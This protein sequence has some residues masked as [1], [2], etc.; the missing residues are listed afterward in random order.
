MTT[1]VGYV[2]PADLDLVEP[3]AHDVVVVGAG[4]T[5]LALALDLSLRGLRPVVLEQNP[6]IHVHGI[7]SRGIA[8]AKRTL[9]I[10]QRYGIAERVLERGFTWSRGRIYLGEE[11]LYGFDLQPDR[12]Q[13]WPAFVNTQ[14][15]YVEEILVER[16]EE[17]GMA[18]LRWSSSVAEI[19]PDAEGVCLQVDT[20]DG[21]YPLRANWV[22]A[23]DG[24]RGTTRKMLGIESPVVL[25]ED[26]WCIVDVR[27][28]REDLNE[29]RFTLESPLVNGA[30]VIQ[31]R[32]G[33]GI[34]RTDWQTV[35]LPDPEAEATPERAT[36][37]LRALLG[38]DDFELVALSP[39]RFKVRVMDRFVH[40]RVVFAGDAAHEIP[41]FGARGGNS[42]IQD[43]D[44]LGWKLAAVVN[45]TADASLLDSYD[46]ER[47]EAARANAGFAGQSARFVSPQTDA[48]RLFR[49]A[50][51]DL[52]RRHEWARALV[53][54]GRLS[55][56]TT[57]TDSPL[58]I[59]DD[60]VF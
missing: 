12:N 49:D 16:I 57:Y 24:A 8:Y 55:T 60:A 34:L 43:A 52:A 17:L 37:R 46:A 20:P 10:F 54:T 27:I 45:G 51:I 15:L 30:A 29:R 31:H 25:F 11:E 5:G 56:A 39:W 19:D 48:E 2:R 53:N 3:A 58:V 59:P 22:V 21:R 35:N 23:A 50:V 28:D 26:L 13:R 38:T 6:G 33:E 36:A 14:Q 4:L 1:Q 9:E 7:A 42:G 18:D 41:P 40:G 32:M 47:G 44:N